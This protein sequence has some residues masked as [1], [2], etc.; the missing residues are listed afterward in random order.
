MRLLAYL[1]IA[2]SVIGSGFVLLTA[3]TMFFVMPIE[4]SDK[5]AF[6]AVCIA[7]S[8]VLAFVAHKLYIRFVRQHED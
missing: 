1:L 2:F 7:I 6:G 3:I 5:L 4:L 8:A